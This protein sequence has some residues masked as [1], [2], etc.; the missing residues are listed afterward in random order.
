MMK[1]IILL[2]ALLVFMLCNVVNATEFTP[3]QKVVLFYRVSDAILQSQNEAEDM[4]K[5]SAELEKELRK[6]YGKRFIVQDIKRNTFQPTS[7]PTFYQKMIKPNQKP[8]M[9][10]IELAGETTTSQHYQNAYGAQAT[11][12]APGINVHLVEALPKASGKEF[13]TVDYGIKTYSSS[14]F[15]LGMDIYAAE[16]DP[17]KN[18][19]NSVR[20]SFRDACK[21]NEQI[22]KYVDPMGAEIEMARFSG[23]FEKMEELQLKKYAPALEEIKKFTAWCQSNE[24]HKPYLQGL[25]MMKTIEQKMMYITQMK[26]MGV[27]K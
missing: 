4:V 5:G 13:A 6:H 24:A 11:G 20:A 19:K 16:T 7:D 1:K 26:N 17:R 8:L 3:T 21:L 27:Y 18:V 9:I 12:Y 10:E 2:T 22:N 15:A 25:E 23:N 14:T